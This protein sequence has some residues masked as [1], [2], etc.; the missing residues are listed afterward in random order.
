MHTHMQ[1]WMLGALIGSA[2]VVT[3]E[4]ANASIVAGWNMNGVDPAISTTLN[5]STGSGTLDF[6]A[7]GANSSVLLGTPMG[8]M[9]GDL[10]GDALSVAGNAF[11]GVSLTIA[12]D[13]TGYEDLVLTFATRRS[14][15]G[16][17]LNRI[18][19]WDGLGWNTAASFAAS[20]T[21]WELKSF[22]LSAI[23]SLE[24]GFA[25]LRITLDGATGATG[26]IR[27][28]NLIF[29]GNALPTPGAVALLG[30]AGLAARRRRD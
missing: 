1:G 8:A 2:T 28:D 9:K 24:N 12:F 19:Y 25:S 7:F 5:A 21:A 13:T 20:T 29:S 23:D 18:E 15:T 14:T 22:D 6:T 4:Q 30:L 3:A 11:N 26:S 17:A 27:F 16:F 10:A